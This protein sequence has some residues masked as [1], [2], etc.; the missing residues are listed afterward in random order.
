MFGLVPMATYVTVR[1][2]PHPVGFVDAATH[3]ANLAAEAPAAL[4]PKRRRT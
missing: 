3:R 1:P 2:A 4:Y